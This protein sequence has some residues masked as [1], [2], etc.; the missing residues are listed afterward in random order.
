[1]SN[2]HCSPTQT[3]A[4]G[5]RRRRRRRGQPINPEPTLDQ[6]KP[7]FLVG[8]P[9]VGK[10]LIF[11]ALTGAYVT[12]SNY[13]GTTVELSHGHLNLGGIVFDV[14]DTPGLYGLLTVTEEE[15]V[16]RSL[17][18]DQRPEIVLHVV[19]AKNLERM[20]PLTLQ[21]KEAGL[22]LILVVNMLDEAA[23]VGLQIDLKLLQTRL[24]LPVVGT[25]STTGEGLE[26]LR[27]TIRGY[28]VNPPQHQPYT[29]S[30][31]ADQITQAQAQ[32]ADLLRQDYT[33]SKT[34]IAE[35]LLAGEPEI[36][37]KL[38]TQEPLY[39]QI[40]PIIAATAERYAEP[41][42][43]VLA[44]QRQNAVNQLLDGVVTERASQQRR[45]STWLNQATV[46]PW[47]GFPLLLLILYFGLYKFVGVFGGGTIVDFIETKFFAEIFNPWIDNLV[48]SYIPWPVLQN[49]IAKDYGIITLGL[50][51]AVAIVL[52]IV[53]TFFLA[54]SI[55]EDSG[56]LPRIALL[57]DRGFK[58]IG[59]NGRAVIPMALGFGCGTMATMVTRTL[60]TKRER[61]LATLLLALAI[62]CSAQLGVIIALL[63]GSAKA[64]ALWS[65]I[66]LGI[67]LLVG[68][69]GA[70][71]L[72]GE[73]PG[74]C[75]E[76]PPLRLP[77]LRNVLAKT[78]TR[79][80][81]YFLEVLPL[82]IL[83]SV[84]IW[85]ADLLKIFDLAL[86]ALNPIVN[87]MGLPNEASVAFLFGFF[88]R[89]YGAAGLYDLQQSGLLGFNQLLVAA[90]TLTLFVPCIAQF[91]VMWKERGWKT[92]I[93]IAGFIVP[94]AFLV[95][96]SLNLILN[97]LGV[98]L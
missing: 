28:A 89:D 17:L 64:L 51:Y 69:L 26:Q 47:T 11:N 40:A 12:V 3:N 65:L 62:P 2:C 16:T 27:E 30:Y 46:N 42:N 22:P 4:T 88:R 38:A 15:R 25:I 34:T 95:G 7:L 10:S 92:A 90:V 31:F 86:A 58:K 98:M 21:L 45:W 73:Q 18:L 20:L 72:P 24:G 5:Q 49:L 61:I 48:E 63:S 55:I 36:T 60:E 96:Y 52:P 14:I 94:F 29:S 9:N 57:L 68:Y 75:L 77:K 66:V 23:A 35:L 54:F 91:S 19:D 82:F 8:N 13:P 56:Y 76:V 87:A 44:L 37:E 78:Y 6:H 74:F 84:I 67:L 97:L 81:W 80:Y 79:M 70:Q 83:A 59:L 85:A 50:R 32:I 43:F 41:L 1:M 93:A 71:V 53:G 39:S 33:L